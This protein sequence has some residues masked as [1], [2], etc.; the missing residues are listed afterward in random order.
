M[1]V[2]KILSFLPE[3][4]ITFS[5]SNY[6]DEIPKIS[7]RYQC[8][9]TAC[10]RLSDRDVWN[11]NFFAKRLIISFRSFFDTTSSLKC[12]RVFSNMFVQ[13]KWR[14]EMQ[15]VFCTRLIWRLIHHARIDSMTSCILHE[16]SD[17]VWSFSSYESMFEMFELNPSLA[18]FASILRFL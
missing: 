11:R 16:S 12:E 10:K 5:F 18:D 3:A 1:T 14:S 15:A 7:S 17:H 13:E 8:M 2:H 6:I 9:H 4:T